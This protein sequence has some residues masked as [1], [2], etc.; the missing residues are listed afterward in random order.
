V[1]GSGLGAGVI[2]HVTPEF[3]PTTPARIVP[4][5]PQF[6]LAPRAERSGISYRGRGM[7]RQRFS[8][9][10]RVTRTVLT[11]T[12]GL[13]TASCGRIAGD[14]DCDAWSNH[15]RPNCES[16][17]LRVY[18]DPYAGVDWNADRR[19]IAQ[20][21]DHVQTRIANIELYDDAGYDLISLFHYSGMPNDPAFWTEPRWPVEPWLPAGY[22]GTLES[23]EQFY[24]GNELVAEWHITGLFLPEYVEYWDPEVDPVR[25]PH[26]YQTDQE[27]IDRVLERGGYPVL[28][29]PWAS[30]S[31]FAHLV[32]LHGVEVYSAFAQMNLVTGVTSYDQNLLMRKVWDDQLERDPQ[33]YGL[34]VNDWHG[35]FCTTEGCEAHPE[36]KD[37]GKVELLARSS[38]YAD[39]EDAF[40]RGAM[41]AVQDLGRPKLSYPRIGAVQVSSSSILVITGAGRVEWISHG[42]RVASGARLEL[43]DLPADARHVRAEVHGDDGS[44]VFV[45]PFWLAPVGDIDGDGKVDARD[46][47]LCD[48]VAAGT[49]DDPDHVAAAAAGC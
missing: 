45:Q 33:T 12:A 6:V 4:A 48:A 26:Q 13:A 32:G 16:L 30:T 36:V 14:E 2:A 24:P 28:A 31:K 8:R 9:L 38:A 7:G 49:D 44:I 20:F 46:R 19:L 22:L 1:V 17:P 41:F 37:S 23:I 42:R 10:A 3:Y 18:H 40:G 34:A 21:H 25:G 29:H 5:P 11:L 35:P 47:E 39:V 43:D 27:L 15:P